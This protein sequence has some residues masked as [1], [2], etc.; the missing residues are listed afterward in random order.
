M[1]HLLWLSLAAAL[2]AGCTDFPQLDAVVTDEARRADYPALIPAEGLLARR[3]LGR[4]AEA[5]GS[6]LMARAERLRARA[7]ILRRIEAVDEETRLRISG[8]LRRLG[9]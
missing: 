6:L 4:L 2:L 9:G 5:D 8:R 7:A 3:E 1:R